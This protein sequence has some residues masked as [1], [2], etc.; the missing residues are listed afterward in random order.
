MLTLTNKPYNSVLVKADSQEEL[1]NTFIRFQ[2]HYES[3]NPKFRNQIFTLGEFKSWYNIEYGSN[4]V[5]DWTGFN[6]PSRVLE[7]FRHGLFDPLTNEES[8]LLNLL[9]YRHDNFYVIGAQDETTLKHELTHALYATNDKYKSEI[10]NVLDKNRKK[11]SK[12]YNHLLKIGYTKEVIYDEIQ[13]YT[14]DGDTNFIW[15]YLDLNTIRKIQEIY[16]RYKIN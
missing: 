6:F 7:S 9:K 13:A 5:T 11:I 12:T 4:Y 8:N 2:E 10:D 3:P 15:E 1:G 16:Q 14:I